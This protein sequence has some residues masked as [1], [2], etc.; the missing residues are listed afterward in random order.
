MHEFLP[1]PRGILYPEIL[2]IFV[3]FVTNVIIILF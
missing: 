1:V 2:A 3:A